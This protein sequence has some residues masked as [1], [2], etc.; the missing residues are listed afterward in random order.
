MATTKINIAI[1]GHS[2]CGKSTLAKDLAAAL[3]YVYIDSGAMYRAIALYLINNNYQV[4]SD[5]VNSELLDKIDI[6]IT[7]VDRRFRVLLNNKDVTD[8]IISID[9]SNIVSEVAAMS[10]VR[11]KLVEIQQQLGHNKGVVMDG[12]D[13]GT[14]VFPTAELKLFIT[15]DI[16]VRTQ[17][18]FLELQEKQMTTPYDEVR[19]NLIHRDHIDSTRADSPLTQAPDAILIDNSFMDQ[20]EQLFLVKKIYGD[21]I[22]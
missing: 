18:R 3:G 20:S 12:R 2:S 9:V 13:I 19:Q 14:V 8:R 4:T 17:R 21:L 6:K 15:A 16:D 22:K 1:D 5:I 7:T 11:R 10:Q